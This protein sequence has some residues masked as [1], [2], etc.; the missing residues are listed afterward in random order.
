MKKDTLNFIT[1]ILI[2]G[3]IGIIIDTFV[4]STFVFTA[5]GLIIGLMLAIKLKRKG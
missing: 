4:G 3:V 2:G 1:D 5:L